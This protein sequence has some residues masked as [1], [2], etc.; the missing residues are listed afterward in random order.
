MLTRIVLEKIDERLCGRIYIGDTKTSAY[1]IP[2]DD[3]EHLFT[4]EQ[5]DEINN[6]M[7]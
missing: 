4:K 1:I 5:L 3:N 6:E 2:C 7:F